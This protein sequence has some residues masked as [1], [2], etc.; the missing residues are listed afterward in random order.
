MSSLLILFRQRGLSSMKVF[1]T[2]VLIPNLVSSISEPVSHQQQS[3][4]NSESTTAKL[5]REDSVCY[6]N[7]PIKGQLFIMCIARLASP[8]AM[9]SIQ[10]CLDKIGKYMMETANSTNHICS[11]S[12][13]SSNRC[14]GLNL[15]W[16]H[17]GYE[18]GRASPY[19]N[20]LGEICRYKLG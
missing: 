20:F 14:Q 3:S 12:S 2:F 15:S 1:Q 9:T 18:D 17:C 4:D 10:V 16:Y 8:L 19:G 5:A 13:N 7:L 11:A 6:A